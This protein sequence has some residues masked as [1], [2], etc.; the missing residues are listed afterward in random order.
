MFFLVCPWLLLILFFI[1]IILLIKKRW[2]LTIF[3]LLLCIFIN[4][5]CQCF[6]FRIWSQEGYSGSISF[7][8]MSFNI[9]GSYESVVAR[10]P[11]IVD[12][13]RKYEPDVVFFAEYPENY[14]DVLDTLL[15]KKYFYTTYS[16]GRT[17][18]FYSKFRLGEQTTLHEINDIGVY[19]SSVYIGGDSLLLYGCHFASNNYTAN[20]QYVTPDSIKSKEDV[21]VYYRNIELAYI[22]RSNEARALVEDMKSIQRPVVALGDF[23]DVGGSK[24]IQTLEDAGLKDAWWEGG[25]GYGAT[26]HKPLP[27]RIDH[28]MYSEHLTLKRIKVINSEGLSDHDALYA[29]FE[30]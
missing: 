28:I 24:T 27:Y 8:V 17:H 30:L 13:V 26:I 21:K 12:L 4:W 9:N 29:E 22:Q 6:P 2:I 11:K 1:S 20:R 5:Q 3:P 19:K 15:K 25:F 16:E 18:C 14:I 7:K 10:A 23:N